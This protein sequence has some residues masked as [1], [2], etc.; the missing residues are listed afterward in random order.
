MIKIK[1]IELVKISISYKKENQFQASV[2]GE[3]RP[4]Y[5]TLMKT[6]PPQGS[7]QLQLR[8]SEQSG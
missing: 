8:L 2:S 5:F 3:L 6:P 7:K 1:Y 4:F